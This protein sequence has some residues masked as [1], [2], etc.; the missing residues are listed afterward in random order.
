MHNCAMNECPVVGLVDML[1]KKWAL[2]IVKEI[3][4]GNT[5]FNVLKRRMKGVTAAVL[6]KR[7][8]ELEEGGI[9]TRKVL[10]KKP[11]EVEYKL[12]KG[13]RHLMECWHKHR[14]SRN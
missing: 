3:Y 7:L 10:K 2:R 13:A 14:G 5:R 9:V 4:E 12:G 1:E 11:L 6:S 8:R